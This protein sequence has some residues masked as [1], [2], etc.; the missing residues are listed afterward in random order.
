MKKLLFLLPFLSLIACQEDLIE[1]PKSLAVE[2][3]Y[4]TATE[5]ESAVNAIYSPLRND[6]CLGG[7][8]PAQLEAYTDYS[9]G[10][11]S[12]AVLSD[13][14]GLNATNITRVGQ[15]WDQL[16]LAIRNANLIVK[17]APAGKSISQADISRYVAEAKFLRAFSYFVLVRNWAGVPIR[18][19]ANMTEQNIKRNTADEVYALILSDLADAETNLPDKAAQSGRPSKWAAKTLLADVYFYRNNYAEARDKADEV[20]KSGKYS[21]VSVA[22]ADDFNKIFGPDVITTTEEIF[23]LKYTRQNGQGFNLVMF[24]HHPGSKLMGAGGYYAHYTDALL[25][26][27]FK[28]WDNAD[29][30]KTAFW[31]KWD[32]GLG[33]NTYL[34]KKFIDPLAPGAS[35]AGN[36]N[37][38]YRYADLLL[39][40][41]EA[42]N[43]ANNGPTTA[44]LEALNQVHRRAYGQNPAVASAVDFKLADYDVN[45]FNDLVLKERGYE[46]QYEAKRWIDLKR[47]G[48][49]KL[50]A[51]IKAG[52]GKDVVDKMLLWP[53]PNSELNYNTALDA[54]KD[55]NPG[56]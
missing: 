51:V 31:Y 24:A 26:N 10:R 29:L 8:Y 56:Y 7:L 27:V 39:L 42:A 23:Y 5:V 50:K 32:I 52:V 46:T 6:N 30:R 19:E 28:N 15:M 55:Q 22:V 43:R 35:G 41:A 21:L 54:A 37:P 45:T 16:Y 13:F 11:G 34:N 4:N 1:Q 36:D 20:I 47:L 9:Y 3:F 44:A 17:N 53:I 25:N 2:T 14:Q 48:A 49:A 40:Y 18:T 12:Y 33:A 38:I